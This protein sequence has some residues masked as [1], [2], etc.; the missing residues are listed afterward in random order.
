M[1]K[2]TMYLNT[3]LNCI[4]KCSIRLF[5]S[6]Y[7]RTY[8]Q[9]NTRTH[10]RI[11]IIIT[12]AKETHLILVQCTN[13][14]ENLIVFPSKYIGGMAERQPYGPNK[15]SLTSLLTLSHRRSMYAIVCVCVCRYMGFHWKLRAKIQNKR[16]TSTHT[17]I[18][19]HKNTKYMHRRQYFLLCF[20]RFKDT[21]CRWRERAN[22]RERTKKKRKKN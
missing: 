12:A 9:T 20:G 5:A 4:W 18:G 2:I 13:I 8:T 11:A 3:A 16:E 7:T 10:A 22:E 15:K 21:K 14:W 19:V 17:Y 1:A 6:V